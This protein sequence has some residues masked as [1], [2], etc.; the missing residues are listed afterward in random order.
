[1]SK[2][3]PN[4]QEGRLELSYDDNSSNSWFEQSDEKMKEKVEVEQARVFLCYKL[5]I[6]KG[7]MDIGVKSFMQKEVQIKFWI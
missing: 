2:E 3:L 7:L 6:V 5:E 4:M 1:M